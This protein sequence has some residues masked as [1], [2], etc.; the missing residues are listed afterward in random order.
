MKES[1]R[2][3]QEAI[4]ISRA[5]DRASRRGDHQAAMGLEGEASQRRTDAQRA[6]D[7]GN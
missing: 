7:R 1:E 6:K 5:A 3:A 4:R 2:L